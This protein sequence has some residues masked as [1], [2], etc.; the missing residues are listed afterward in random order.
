MRWMMIVILILQEKQGTPEQYQNQINADT[1]STTLEED[2]VTITM[3]FVHSEK[4]VMDHMDLRE[5]M[6]MLVPQV[7]MDHLVNLDPMGHQDKKENKDLLDHK[8]NQDHQETMSSLIVLQQ[9]AKE[10]KED[11]ENQV[12]QE[13]QV[14]PELLGPREILAYLLMV[15]LV[16]QVNLVCL[17]KMVKMDDRDCQVDQ[18]IKVYLE[19]ETSPESSTVNN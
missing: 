3:E 1:A 7:Y 19:Q 4:A 14:N 12:F 10:I 2:H 13:D 5:L 17:E 11:Q 15:L 18:V 8:E 16:S 6:V 9:E